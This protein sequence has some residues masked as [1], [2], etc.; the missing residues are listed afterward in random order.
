MIVT[1]PATLSKPQKA[2]SKVYRRPV[3]RPVV[4]GYSHN[5]ATMSVSLSCASDNT[6]QTLELDH[7][8][9]RSLTSLGLSAMAAMVSG[10][11]ENVCGGPSEW[12]VTLNPGT[13]H[14]VRTAH[15]RR[16]DAMMSVV[17]HMA[18]GHAVSF[19]EE[20]A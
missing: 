15:R 9:T 11:L 4:L 1:R 3:L 16:D 19:H 12:I 7:R 18:A 6:Y 13:P 14:A 2:D 5:C 10:K 8:E 20:K 17:D